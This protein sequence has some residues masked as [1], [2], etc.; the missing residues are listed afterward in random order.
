MIKITLRAARVNAGLRLV[1]AS[2]LFGINKD[3]LSKYEHDSTNVPRSIFIK[4]EEIYAIPVENI[5]FG[6][7]SEFFRKKKSA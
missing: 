4:I 5:F 3:T 6:P 1:E 2:K 7:E